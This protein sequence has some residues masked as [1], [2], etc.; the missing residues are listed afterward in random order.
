MFVKAP[1][2]LGITSS[3]GDITVVLPHSTTTKYAINYQTEGGDYSASVP[4]D[5]AAT[6]NKITLDSGGGNVSISEAS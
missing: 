5:L 1:A 4:V 2:Y 3:G 6:A